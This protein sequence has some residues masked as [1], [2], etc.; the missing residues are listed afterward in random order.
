MIRPKLLLIMLMLAGCGGSESFQP[1]GVSLAGTW[2]ISS[3]TDPGAI[4]PGSGVT[5]NS[6]SMRNVPVTLE[7]TD[8]PTLWVGR[9]E[10]GGTLEC[11][12]NGESPG[13]SPYNPS[14]FLMVTKTGG[15]LSIGLPNGLVVY[16]GELVAVNQMS[17]TVT[18]E[19]DGRVG[20]WTA[21]RE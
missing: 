14:L 3:E 4:P 9:M 15:A 17:G 12:V 13:P 10:D 7:A 20:T 19:L 18:G 11:E 16:T 8:D 1:E 2:L 6:C 5:S 21:S